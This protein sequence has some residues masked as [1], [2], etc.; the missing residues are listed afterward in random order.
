MR[1][2]AAAPPAPQ[3]EAQAALRAGQGAGGRCVVPLR[4]WNRIGARELP[5][6]FSRG[7]SRLVLTRPRRAGGRGRDGGPSKCFRGRRGPALCREVRRRD[8][9]FA[10][11]FKKIQ[12]GVVR[13]LS[14]RACHLHGGRTAGGGLEKNKGVL[15]KNCP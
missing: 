14:E 5:R 1:A 12:G 11:S 13:L 10:S 2:S 9:R 3:D 6:P 4:G 8:S 15:K 7:H